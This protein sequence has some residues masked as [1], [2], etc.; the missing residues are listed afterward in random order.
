MNFKMILY[1]YY[2]STC[3]NMKHETCVI[4]A[5]SVS[6]AVGLHVVCLLLLYLE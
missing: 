3:E 4:A 1:V 2:V 5:I 6:S